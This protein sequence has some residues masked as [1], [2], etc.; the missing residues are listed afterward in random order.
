MIDI[1]S[2]KW[3]FL[4]YTWGASCPVYGNGEKINISKEKNMCC[5]DSCN[6][7]K[8][9]ASNHIGTH[10]DFPLHFS[11]NGKSVLD[12][13]SN[14]FIHSDISL[15]N[16][17]IEPGTLI[18][19]EHIKK[20]SN[21]ISPTS[22]IL[23]IKT[24]FGKFRNEEIYWKKSIGIDSGVANFLRDRFPKINTI[25]IDTISISSLEHR[26]IGRIVHK[27]FLDHLNPILIIED[28]N[29]E[30]IQDQKLKLVIALPLRIENA[31]GAPATI[32]AAI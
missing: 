7:L 6:T 21:N 26:E 11:K 4:S 3:V 10:Y 15:I 13:N 16:I 29:L 1:N 27:E 31:D 9:A 5:G 23:I 25:A 28:L 30:Y 24:G 20:L 17:S 22:T 19:I 14:S 12:Y 18:N 32:I 2:Y 8:L